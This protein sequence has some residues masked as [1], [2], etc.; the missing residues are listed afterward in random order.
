MVENYISVAE[1]D[2]IFCLQNFSAVWYFSSIAILFLDEAPAVTARMMSLFQTPPTVHFALL[3]GT[4][5]DIK[6][7]WSKVCGNKFQWAPSNNTIA[8]VYTDLH[9]VKFHY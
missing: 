2:K 5:N 7:A 4:P 3:D 6:G 9:V 1:W 8:Q